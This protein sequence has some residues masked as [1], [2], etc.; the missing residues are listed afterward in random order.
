MQETQETWVQSWGPE[1]LLE[2]EMAT[3]S[4]ILTWKIPRAEEPGR[5]KSTGSQQI[6]HDWAGT[7][8][9]QQPRVWTEVLQQWYWCP[10]IFV[11]FC[12][13][14]SN[15]SFFIL[16]YAATVIGGAQR[17]RLGS[18][19]KRGLEGGY[20][21]FSLHRGGGLLPHPRS[22]KWIIPK[23]QRVTVNSELDTDTQ[24]YRN[25]KCP[26]CKTADTGRRWLLAVMS[27]EPGPS[28]DFPTCSEDLEGHI[29]AQERS[30]RLWSLTTDWPG[31]YVQAER[32]G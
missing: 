16:M 14:V 13:A 5:L 19:F 2:E 23:H 32:E 26:Q 10:R 18:S 27:V 17:V 30:E 7:L 31:G 15:C 25:D 21:P 22:M 6:G 8:T 20:K 29:H 12:C 28:G 1:D 24:M 3:H 4:S 11:S 9:V